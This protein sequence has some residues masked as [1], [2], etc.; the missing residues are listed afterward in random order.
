MTGVIVVVA[1]SLI[2]GSIGIWLQHR[3]EKQ[4]AVAEALASSLIEGVEL[5][6]EEEKAERD[7]DKMAVYWTA[8]GD[9]GAFFVF[10]VMRPKLHCFVAKVTK[11][12]ERGI[13]V[14]DSLGESLFLHYETLQWRRAEESDLHDAEKVITPVD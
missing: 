4:G 12:V 10:T 9:S 2:L 7:R 14:E 6:Q 11:A 5:A 1:G 8:M 13:I 3:E